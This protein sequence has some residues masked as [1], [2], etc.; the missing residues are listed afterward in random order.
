MGMSPS[1]LFRLTN[2]LSNILRELN[3]AG[4][5][6]E[7]GDDF[8]KYRDYRSQQ[9]DR[10]AMYSMFDVAH[11]YVDGSNGFWVCGFNSQEEVVHT[12]AA[13]LLD[14]S[15]ISLATHLNTH[16]HK[17]ITPDT[18]PDPDL[19][20]YKGPEALHTIT[21][22]VCYQGDFWLRASGLGGPRGKGATSLLSRVLLEIVA[23]TWNP[24]YVFALVPERLA[25]K[26]AHLRYGY[27]HCEPGQWLGPDQQI[28]E[29]DY[30][31]WMG[32]K[33]MANLLSRTPHLLQRP[34]TTTARR[35]TAISLENKPE[36]ITTAN[37]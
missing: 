33:D 23:A 13:R 29:E 12:Q 31:I 4:L 34:T 5:R 1:R 17:Y 37:V 2:H 8:T 15:G 32:A 11:S 28:T 25:A 26:G 7:I 18:T 6:I 36:P 20:F 30:L 14:M 19:T 21:G 16:R 3:D 9:P 22:N 24:H 35:T 27:C 10:G